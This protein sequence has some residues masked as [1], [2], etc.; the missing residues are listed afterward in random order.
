[1]GLPQTKPMTETEYLAFE[2]ATPERH[3]FVDGEIFAMAT[4]SISHGR[5]TTNVNSGLHVRLN[6]TSCEV[7]GKEMRVRSGPI[8][9]ARRNAKGM[10]SYPD[11]IVVCGEPELLDRTQDTILNPKVIIEV[12]SPSTEAFDR[13]G[14]FHRYRDYNP[15]LTDYVLVAQDKPYVEHYRRQPDG[16]WLCSYHVG[17]KAKVAIESIGVT[18]RL[19]DVYARVVFNE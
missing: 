5:I 4:E 7:F 12:L 15:T 17:L 3:L 18:L 11:A 13:A 9:S 19:R 16:N 2:R 8:T 6:G 1:M 10:Y 14:K